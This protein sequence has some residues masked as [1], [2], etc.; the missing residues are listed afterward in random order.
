MKA[1]ISEL[2]IKF[3]IIFVVVAL[4]LLFTALLI[5]VMFTNYLVSPIKSLIR[6]TEKVKDGELNTIM[7]IE[8]PDNDEFVRLGSAFNDMTIQLDR[9][10]NALLEAN[11]QIDKRRRYSEAV[12]SGVSAGV[13]ALNKAQEVVSFNRSA[14]RVL[15]LGQ[16]HISGTI[17]DCFPEVLPLLT[18]VDD[19]EK[20]GEVIKEEITIERDAKKIILS[21]RVS[22]AIHDNTIEGYVITFDDITT[23]ISA[24]RSAAWRDVAR[25][26]AHEIKNPLTPIQLSAERLKRKYA[27]QITEEPENYLRYIDTI[28]SNV[29]NIG[30]MVEEFVNFSRMPRPEFKKENLSSIISE[31]IFAEQCVNEAIR[32]DFNKPSYPVWVLCDKSQINQALINLCKNA[33]ESIANCSLKRG[34]GCIEITLRPDGKSCIV[35]IQ[36][37]GMGFPEDLIDR[38]TEPYVTTR[39]KGT[40]LG[41]AIVKKIME[42][43][44]VSITLDNRENGAY[45]RLVFK[46]VTS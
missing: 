2:Q 29:G 13:I 33:V 16:E 21:V 7:K 28:T 11:Y 30:N 9:Q 3:S 44:E 24:Q 12:L 8:G 22:T 14:P 46:T 39:A 27:R 10:R 15:H 35:E 31:V 23:L 41:L 18:K 32:F 38:L 45:V 34:E 5:G 25:R 42:D 6:A 19:S 43:H 17:H 20:L 1:T 40:G 36:D 4:L 26:I 37:N